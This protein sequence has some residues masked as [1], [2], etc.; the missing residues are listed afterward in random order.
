MTYK[1]QT[2]ASRGLR[3][4]A[5]P[6]DGETL[7]VLPA[8]S[9][10]EVLAEERWLRVRRP[11]GEMGF[12]SAE[13]VDLVEQSDDQQDADPRSTIVPFSEYPFMSHD[14]IRIHRDFAPAMHGIGECAGRRE[15]KIFVTSSLRRP[16]QPVTNAI[17][18]PAR[19]SNHHVGHAI[20]MNIVHRGEWFN[21]RR[22]M[23]DRELPPNVE[24]FLTDIRELGLRWGGDFSTP[25]PVHIDD[26][27]NRRNPEAY[28]QKLRNVW[29]YMEIAGV[30][31]ELQE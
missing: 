3:F 23:P 28:G 4:R 12:V 29:E 31:V 10:L 7:A 19:M 21:S 18:T 1:V 16:N 26:G 13:Y 8:G 9:R 24:L 30:A 20:D 2:N 27:L 5:S 15:L 14:V 22:L 11:S 25:D 6:H 17:V